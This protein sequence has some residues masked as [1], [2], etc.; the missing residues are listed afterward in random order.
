MLVSLPVYITGRRVLVS[1]PVYITGRRV[2]VSLPVSLS[3]F[4]DVEC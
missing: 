2:L 4:P 3:I 1:L